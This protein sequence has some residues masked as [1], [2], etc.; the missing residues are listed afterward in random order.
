MPRSPQTTSSLDAKVAALCKQPSAAA[1]KDAK[2]AFAGAVDAWSKVEIFRFGPIVA[3][4]S[5]RAAVLLAR[6]QEPRPAPDRGR[7]R[8]DG[9][10]RDRA[11]DARRQERGAAGPAGARISALWRRRGR[12][13][14]GRRRAAFRCRFA[15]S[16]AANIDGIAKKVMRA[17]ATALPTRRRFSRRARPIAALSRAERGDARA[18]QIVRR[19]HRARARPEA[20]QA[21]RHVGRPSPSPSSP[22]S[23]AAISPSPT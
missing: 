20:R 12:P 14:Q 18:V 21:A 5:L 9:R 15:S 13:R 23:G 11:R 6:P 19:W 1:L 2:D 4:P 3:G 7:P 17:G 8:Q 10:E 22:P 16:I